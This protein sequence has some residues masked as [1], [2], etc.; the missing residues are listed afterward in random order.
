MQL[1]NDI[2]KIV[3]RKLDDIT[4]GS[5]S[6]KILVHDNNYRYLINEELS[7]VPGKPM[8]GSVPPKK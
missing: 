5:V 4:H 7:I 1:P 3:E 6:L 2:V 8:S